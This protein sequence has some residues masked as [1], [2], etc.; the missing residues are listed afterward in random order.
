MD[1]SKSLTTDSEQTTQRV[2]QLLAGETI[3]AIFIYGQ[4]TNFISTGDSVYNGTLGDFAQRIPKNSS[5]Q[6]FNRVETDAEHK[7]GK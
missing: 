7:N 6:L 3:E 4:F 2:N 5:V 1:I